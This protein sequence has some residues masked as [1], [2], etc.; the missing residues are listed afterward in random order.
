[1]EDDPHKFLG[2]SIRRSNS[3]ADHFQFLKEKLE[4]KLSNLNETKV[5]GEFKAAVYRRYVLSS[6]HFH[7]SVHNI[8][9]THMDILDHLARKFLKSWLCFP[10]R[11]VTDQGI[12]H[13]GILGI[14]YPSQVYL[15]SHMTSFI[16]LK[17]SKDPV[18]REA[19]TCQLERGGAW[20]K[21][22]STAFEC[23]E[24]FDKLS[25]NNSIIIPGNCQRATRWLE[26]Q[27]LKHAGKSLVAEKYKERSYQTSS[28]LEVQG[29]LANLLAEEKK[30][31]HW[32]SLIYSVP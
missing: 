21:K 1:M 28:H 30:S 17:L 4:S 22:Y 5:R 27:R 13:P 29:V 15:E 32:Q 8:H 18:V 26:I 12:V 16:S 6:L 20:I 10:N 9:K 7:F 3:P 11:G 24:M 25:E 14:K 2:S 19:V 23:Q 31:M